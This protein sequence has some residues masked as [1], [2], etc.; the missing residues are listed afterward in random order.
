MVANEA[1]VANVKEYAVQRRPELG[2]GYGKLG[3]RRDER[4][5]VLPCISVAHGDG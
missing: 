5:K 3:Q 4:K 2:N 1:V